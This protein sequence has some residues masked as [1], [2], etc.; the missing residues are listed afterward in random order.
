MNID[1]A[2]STF[3]SLLI[4][5]WHTSCELIKKGWQNKWSMITSSSCQKKPLAPSLVSPLHNH[6]HSKD[7]QWERGKERMA[8]PSIGCAQW[9][10]WKSGV[11]W[12]ITAHFKYKTSTWLKDSLLTITSN[13]H[14]CTTGKNYHQTNKQTDNSPQQIRHTRK[15]IKI[16]N[17]W[18]V[19][20]F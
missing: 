10:C 17:F 19:C 18:P 15:Q 1:T 5:P 2:Q 16:R 20:T 14:H 3:L 13:K 7:L 4:A 11:N 12:H 8:A 9:T 6:K